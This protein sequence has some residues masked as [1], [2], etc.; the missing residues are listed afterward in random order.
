MSYLRSHSLTLGALLFA[1]ILVYAN[2]LSNPFVIDDR[3]IIFRNFQSRETWTLRDLFQRSLFAEEPSE[4]A[5]F[6]PLTMLTFALN[7]Q[8]AGERPQ[9]YRAVNVALHLLVVALVTLLLS[10]V[11]G[12]WVGGF[13]ALCF[14]LH[15]IDVQAVSYISSRGD[16]LYTALALLSLL[17]WHHGNRLQGKKKN[18]YLAAALIAF[19]TG[20]FAKETMI[21]VPALALAMD[22]ARN[23]TGSWSQKIREDSGWYLGFAIL[24]ATYLV[25]RLHAGFPLTYEAR[26]E[27]GLVPRLLMALK[28]LSLYVFLAFYPVRLLLFR[29]VPIPQSFLEWQVMLGIIILGAFIFLARLCW[30]W[31]REVAFGILWF[32]VSILPVLNLTLLI[33]PMME[34]WLYLPLIGLSLAFVGGIRIIADRLGELRGA[35]IGLTLLALLLAA[36]TVTRNAEWS[37]LVKLLSQEASSNPGYFKTWSWLGDAMLHAGLWNEAVQAYKNS[38]ALNSGIGSS[39]AG[40]GEALWL[41]GRDPEAEAVLTRAASLHSK[42]PQVHFKLGIHRLKVGKN[43]EAVS[44]LEKSIILKPTSSAYHALGSAYSRLGRKAQAEQALNRAFLMNRRERGLH[45]GF[46]VYL[47]NLYW[48]AGKR[49]EAIEEWRLALGFDPND[50]EARGL[51]QKGIKTSP[52][53]EP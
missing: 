10:R 38:L 21:V 14:A 25:I 42:D 34:H 26:M 7:Y 19:F 5:Y 52:V 40:L 16:L 28:L 32:L 37:N 43:L 51:L 39:W 41:A 53:E 27:L 12:L 31:R 46:H 8:L 47:G 44:S 49:H 36:R 13:A 48:R 45:A 9:G 18:L 2:S 35:A 15:P 23:P 22:L 24:L 1:T 4:S 33:A 17:F 3:I 50:D 11:A 29:T 30:R 20:L 6:R